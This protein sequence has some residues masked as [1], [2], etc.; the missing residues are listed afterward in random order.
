MVD[1]YHHGSLRPTLIEQGLELVIE[2]GPSGLTVRELTARVGVSPSAIYRHFPDFE[3]VKSAV[4]QASRQALG[5]WMIEAADAVEAEADPRRAAQLRF[6]TLGEAYLTFAL[7][8]PNVF[9]MA[10]HQTEALLAQPDDPDPWRVLLDSLE[11]L[12]RDGQLPEHLLA[13]APIIAW[14]S[15]HGLAT[16]LVSARTPVTLETRSTITAVIDGVGRALELPVWDPIE[17]S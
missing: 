9:S 7:N 1:R 5:T 11:D 15:V 14:S 3:H 10:F 6:R 4:A 17:E 16:I 13:D 12:A 2:T 8:E